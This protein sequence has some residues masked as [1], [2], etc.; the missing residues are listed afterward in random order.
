MPVHLWPCGIIIVSALLGSGCVVRL[1]FL[2][3]RNWVEK[4]LNKQDEKKKK[5]REYQIKLKELEHKR[6]SCYGKLFLWIHREIAENK[7]SKELEAAFNELQ[8]VEEEIKNLDILNLTPLDA[9]NLLYKLKE[10]L[11]DKN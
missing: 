6:T 2:F 8:K 9:L 3:I 5:T 1:L 10:E 7:C 11:G 4:R